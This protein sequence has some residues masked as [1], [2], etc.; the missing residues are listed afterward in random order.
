MAIRLDGKHIDL[1]QPEAQAALETAYRARTRPECSCVSPAQPMYIA[2]IGDRYFVKRMPGTGEAHA[3]DCQSFEA[4]EHLSGLAELNG[5]AIQESAD[6]GT[7]LLK[8]DFAL[9]K[10][11]KQ[12]APPPSSGGMATEA[13]G[14][15]KKMGLT[16]LLHFLWH[17]GELTKWVPAME[18][19]RWWAV[20]R[21]A[22]RRAAASKTAKGLSLSDVLFVPEHFTVD[23]AGALQEA[24]KR[25]FD[26]IARMG[27]SGT[28][29]GILIA[30]YK[31]HG[32]AAFGS[33]FSFKHLPDCYF[34]ADADL[35]KRFDRVFEDKLV[36][37]EMSED[38]HFIVIATFSIARAGYP[39]LQTIGGMLVTG[40]FL[41][42]ETMK[43]A[44]LLRTLVTQRRRF[45]KQLRFNLKADATVASVVLSDTEKPVAAF[46]TPPGAAPDEV[47]AMVEMI[48]E[49][50]YPYWVWADEVTM[51]ALPPIKTRSEEN[52]S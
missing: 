6:D 32:P 38:T 3:P 44:E 11:G 7:T 2:K 28:A 18:K 36:L 15:P 42:F 35:T 47:S 24:R 46:V 4:P 37:A 14:N 26:Q 30:E 17:E 16:A 41:P 51:P 45:I 31:S 49:A 21:S 50:G 48:D 20:V 27:G 33:K 19:K 39:A 23:R 25:K 22:L 10:R 5:T 9:T 1:T 43:E 12:A 29:L 34:F 13:V 40:E 52:A 8:L